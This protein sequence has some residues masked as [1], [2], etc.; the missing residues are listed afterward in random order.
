MRLAEGDIALRAFGPDDEATLLAMLSEPEVARWWPVPDFQRDAGWIIEVD[1]EPSG[2]LEYHEEDYAWY[3]SVA[4]DIMLTSSLHGHGYG[5]RVLR[6]AISHFVAKGH[7]RFTLDP[8]VANERAIRSYG[9]VGFER[10]GVMRAYERSPHGGFHDAL[11]MEL[12]VPEAIERDALAP[13]P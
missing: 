8:N 10:V 7:H 4:F 5:R 6:L 13:R 2:W 1:G 12:I 9:A 11:L 3:P